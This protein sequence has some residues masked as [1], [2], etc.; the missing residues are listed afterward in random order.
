MSQQVPRIV[1]TGATG[2]LGG[3]ILQALDSQPVTLVAAARDASRLPS[4]FAGETRLGDLTDP[5]YRREVVRDADVVIHAGTWS[6]F[7][8]HAR[9]ESDL[10]LDPSIDLIDRAA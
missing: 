8:G 1:V 4:W 7:W 10:F 6:S 3:N 9:E 2:F 5:A